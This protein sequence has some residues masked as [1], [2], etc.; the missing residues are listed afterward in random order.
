MIDLLVLAAMLGTGFLLGWWAGGATGAGG[1]N[2]QGASR[3]AEVT[4]RL[5]S[6]AD[7]VVHNLG[8]HH[9]HI[10]EIQSRLADANGRAPEDLLEI[11]E[12]LLATNE[13]IQRELQE[14]E[15]ALQRQSRELSEQVEAARTDPLTGIGNRLAFD[16]ELA[17]CE[18]AHERSGETTTLVMVDVDHFKHINDAYGHP[19]GDQVL[20]SVA[21]QLVARFRFLGVVCRYGGEE[22]AVVIPSRSVAENAELIEETRKAISQTPCLVDGERIK[23]TVSIGAAQFQ[24]GDDAAALVRKA[25]AALY[26]AKR[27]GRNRA[28]VHDGAAIV[29][30]EVDRAE[31]PR[32]TG[33]PLTREELEVADLAAGVS[34]APTFLADVARRLEQIPT[35][36]TSFSVLLVQIDAFDTLEQDVGTPRLKNILRTIRMILKS[37][38]RPID[39]V[40]TLGPGRFGVIL[41]GVAQDDAV[42]LAERI[43][44]SVQ[45]QC[46]SVKGAREGPISVS[47][48]V[49]EAKRFEPQEAL[50]ERLGTLLEKAQA[51]GANCTFV[52]DGQTHRL[53]GAGHISLVSPAAVP[54]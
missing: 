52:H 8:S 43:R 44:T 38:V 51:G 27:A 53:A 7:E 28:Y 36:E 21:E 45:R 18:R 5:R 9:D 40:G 46:L 32:G 10:E 50:M 42:A 48:A 14:A 17:S 15:D 16:E 23:V 22:F 1:W 29:P 37:N 30:L 25:D 47:I 49:A 3:A 19:A 31:A 33:E 12:D 35:I 34:H 41:P 6:I 54:S 20:R 26:Q 13:K 4:G 24:L 11:L 39:H 2:G